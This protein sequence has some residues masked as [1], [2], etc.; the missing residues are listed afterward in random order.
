M[1]EKTINIGLGNIQS[2]SYFEKV[3]TEYF[4]RLFA[5]ALV[6]TK[7]E[8]TAKDVVSDVFYGLWNSKKDLYTV[9]ELKSYLYT[10]V[11]HQ[12]I[13]AISK[14][15]S[16]YHSDKYNLTIATIDGLDPEEL[17]LGK[18]LS[19]FV[20]K[21]VNKLPPQCGLVYRMVREDNLSYQEVAK[22]L[23]ISLDTVKHHL[24]TAI[25]KLKL[26]LENHFM[27]SKVVK[28][29]SGSKGNS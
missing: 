13:R 24:K 5:Y 26:E 20:D 22:E 15:F 1:A 18:E 17:L 9:K 14:D 11:K 21:A 12:A 28:W 7:S 3:Y 8:S 25:K 23:G 10:S 4:D 16:K 6:I 29:V 2:D 19:E 27:E